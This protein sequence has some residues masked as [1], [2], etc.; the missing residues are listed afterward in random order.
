MTLPLSDIV[1]IKVSVGP[2]STVR[3]SFN[4]GLIV[5][6][7]KIMKERVKVYGKTVEMIADG[8]KGTE[9][10]FL[11]AQLYFSQNPKPHKIAIGTWDKEKETAAQAMAACREDNTEWYI[12]YVCGASTEQIIE[13]AKYI[14]SATPECTYAYTTKDEDVL[15]NKAGNLAETLKKLGIHRTIGQFSTTENA[16]VAIMGYA[17]GSNTQTSGSAYTLKFKKEL[18]VKPESLKSTQVTILKNNNCNAYINRGSVYDLFEDGVMADGTPFDEV[19]NLDILQNDIQTAVINA[20]QTSS[21][22]A[23]TDHGMN[24]LLN[25]IIGP[26]EKARKNGFIAEG[27]WNTAEVLSVKTGDT[28]SRGYIIL[29]DSI[30]NQSQADR[31]AR[32][33]PPV[34]VLAKLAGS[35]EYVSIK[36]FTNR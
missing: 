28:L 12:A 30:D 35:I 24:N 17:M 21:K 13:V 20:L 4:L 9:P 22:I 27:V 26:L 2:I 31:E 29:A 10:E 34:Y 32:K 33:A 11:A 25:H 36:V 16:I 15:N 23:Q 7:S 8:W 3:S 6:P 14:D 19:L 18:G 1:D 5:G